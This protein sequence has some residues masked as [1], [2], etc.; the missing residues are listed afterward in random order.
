MEVVSPRTNAASYTPL[1]HLFAALAR[2]G[3][4]SL[5]IA[6]DAQAR[7]FYARL[8]GNGARERLEAPL[9]A[10]YP[11]ASVRTAAADPARQLP[12]EQIAS[13]ALEL[14]EPEY[15][16]LRIPRDNEI[17]ADRAPQADPLL[18]VLAALGGQPPGWRHLDRSFRRRRCIGKHA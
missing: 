6:G 17:V 9:G 1:E 13:C 7:R 3:A 4:V 15:L 11:Q 8:A 16:P 18:G 14:Q 12:G 5:E 10:V 2:A